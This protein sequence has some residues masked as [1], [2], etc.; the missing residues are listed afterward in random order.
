MSLSSS[1]FQYVSNLVRAQ[2]A[3]V[4]ESGKEYLVESRLA[5]LAKAEGLD[6]V[7]DVVRRL[8]REPR[9]EIVDLVVEAMTTNETLFF[10]DNHPFQSLREEVLP[11]VIERNAA[12]KSLSI[13][14]A[15][16]SSGQEPYS[17]CMLL[18]DHFPEL[19]NWNVRI[20]ASDISK[21]MLRRVKTGSYSQLEVNRGLPAKMLVKYFSKD[22]ATWQISPELIKM[23]EL[24]E[25]NLC[26]SW[27]VLPSFDIVMIRNVLIYF[28]NETKREIMGKI[29][30]L[31]KPGGFMFLGGSET[32][33]NLDDAFARVRQGATWAYQVAG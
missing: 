24:R 19:S 25:I 1:D 29:R 15:A 20:I 11:R 28:D 9:G 5:P 33:I 22:G 18:R 10:R 6:S 14:C 21:S 3:L 7:E 13:W 23:L 27:P 31:L 32:T 30:G 2:S 17:L 26:K 16:S 8:R 4:L 12:T